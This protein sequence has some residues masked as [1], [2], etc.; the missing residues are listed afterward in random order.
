MR[1]KVISLL[2]P[3]TSLRLTII[4]LAC[5]MVLV[6]VGTLD[7]V[8]IGI[9]ETQNRYF[10][11]F[12]LFFTPPST[13]LH[14]PWFPGGYLVGGVLL[15]NLIAAHIARFRFTWK[16]AGIVILHSGLILLLI[17]QL[18]TS[19]FQIESQMRLDQGEIKNYS[20]SFYH[21]ELAVIDTT[22][23]DSD[24]VVSIPDSELYRNHVIDLPQD[25]LR[26]QINDYYPNS[27]LVNP[28]QLP[29]PNYPHLQLGPMAVAVPVAKT[30]KQ[31][32]RNMPSAAI[33]V[34]QEPALVGSWN[35]ATEFPRPVSFEA[36][37]KKYELVL[38]PKRF[39]K[40]FSV[41]LLQFRHD[42][43]AGTDIAKNFS[44]RVRL[45]DP[46]RHEDRESL[47]FMNHPLRYRGLTFYQAGF[48][49]NDT[50][51]VLQVVKNPGAIIPY[52]SCLLIVFGILLQFGMH[53]VSFIRRRIVT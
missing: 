25:R 39:Y 22:A 4:C 28:S 5:A 10:K 43:Y 36:S 37:G 29:N 34:Y 40:P 53:L 52:V 6:F 15:V 23:P 45:L 51:T 9:Y 7:Q 33:S 47:I 38:R 31:D 8:H 46:S 3:L 11:S 19:I 13:G 24:L 48:D 32:E 12:F 27:V 16:K 49:N 21:D 44:S 14:I 2:R 17:G 42:T 30:Y 1:S 26:V 18:V 50:T 35:L 41:K 20:E